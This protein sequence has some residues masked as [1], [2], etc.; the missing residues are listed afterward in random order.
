MIYRLN[1]TSPLL[2]DARIEPQHPLPSGALVQLGRI[3]ALANAPGSQLRAEY[4]EHAEATLGRISGASFRVIVRGA[5]LFEFF[6]P[7]P[8]T[9]NTRTYLHVY[10]YRRTSTQL[11]TAHPISDGATREL[12]KTIASTRA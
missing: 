7:R 12:L 4:A 5:T 8:T 10:I 9:R 11:Y 2:T 6:Q 1:N 3:G